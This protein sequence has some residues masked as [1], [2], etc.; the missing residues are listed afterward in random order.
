MVETLNKLQRTNSFFDSFRESLSESVMYAYRLCTKH[1]HRQYAWRNTIMRNKKSEL[2]GITKRLL[3]RVTQTRIASR[4]ATKRLTWS[5]IIKRHTSWVD[6][7]HDQDAR[8]L[9]RFRRC[10]SSIPLLTWNV[11][12]ASSKRWIS[13]WNFHWTGRVQEGSPLEI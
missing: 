4:I 5:A 3:V 8:D 11:L 6:H 13:W 1:P 7:P 10:I 12:R 9:S 2:Q